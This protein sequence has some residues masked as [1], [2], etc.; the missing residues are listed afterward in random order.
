[1]DP[2]V[3]FVRDG[4]IARI[5]LDSQ[6]NRNALSQRLL[7][8]LHEALDRSAEA[9]VIVIGHDGLA[10]CSGADLRERAAGLNDL[11]PLVS[12]IERIQG[13]NAPVIAAITGA[14]RAGG[15]GLVAA[16]DLVIA[17]DKATFGCPEVRIGV[18]PAI[19]AVGLI[20]RCGWA[21]MAEPLLTGEV[22]DAA[23]AQA[24]GLV[25]ETADDVARRVNALCTSLLRAAPQA[26]AATKALLRQP[27]TMAE[28][29][30]LSERLFA[31]EEAAEGMSAFIDK[32]A[33]RWA[34][35]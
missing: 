14:V 12:A 28:A 32:R 27:Q 6:H 33:P 30:A 26:V 31:S 19:V 11:G 3:R 35:E 29:Q 5:T 25:T 8:E 1:M 20:A 21:A 22:F 9:R 23:H 4:D 34:A 13:A 10:F 16:C 15:M 17:S 7:D 18:A 24:I 2:L